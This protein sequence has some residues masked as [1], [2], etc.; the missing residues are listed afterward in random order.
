MLVDLLS[1]SLIDYPGKKA[2]VL[3]FSGCNFR[4]SFCQNSVLTRGDIAPHITNKEVL[5]F[6]KK[7]KGTLDAVCITGGE[8]LLSKELPMLIKA[9]KAMGYLVKLDTNG[10]NLKALK[11]VAPYL[12][13]I[14]INL[15]VAPADYD[16]F[17][18]HQGA[19]T[20]VRETLSWI[21]KWSGIA[22]DI[23]TAVLPEWHD[24][25]NLKL[26]SDVVGRSVWFLEQYHESQDDVLNG[27]IREKYSDA[28][29]VG[30]GKALKCKVI[31]PT[32]KHEGREFLYE[33]VAP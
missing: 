15:K 21:T 25:A 6:L 18:K 17:T 13:Y 19:W 4:C 2:A 32:C 23:H 31:N 29:L 33:S 11:S 5:S 16:K 1:S 24:W 3:Y 12:D 27:R 7:Q 14:T 10:S 28:D 8:P 22:Y 30:F 26:I 20:K 9:I